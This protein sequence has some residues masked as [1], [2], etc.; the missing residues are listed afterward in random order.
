M[1]FPI[2]ELFRTIFGSDESSDSTIPV[3]YKVPLFWVG[4]SIAFAIC[5]YNGMVTAKWFE[6]LDQIKLT[7]NMSN[8]F[9]GSI[10]EYIL[11]FRCEIFFV[12]I[13]LAF[14]LPKDIIFSVWFF[15]IFMK[16]QQFIAYSM[17]HTSFPANWHSE[18]NFMVAQGGGAMELF[19]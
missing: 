12:V 1:V 6:G 3:I 15:Y 14:L 18:S 4:F 8:H 2:G 13:G 7:G 19:G 16:F 5:F 10:L 11:P 17:G 9:Q